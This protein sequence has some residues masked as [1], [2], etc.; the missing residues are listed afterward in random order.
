MPGREA[1]AAFLVEALATFRVR[2]READASED[3]LMGAMRDDLEKNPSDDHPGR[4][5]GSRRG[6]LPSHLVGET[7]DNGT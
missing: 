1:E 2:L 5:P 7:D 4:R 6:P 3:A